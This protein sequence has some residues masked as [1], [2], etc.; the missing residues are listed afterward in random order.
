MFTKK[1]RVIS[2]IATVCMLISMLACVAIP[3]YAED[4]D[5][6]TYPSVQ[7]VTSVETRTATDYKVTNGADWKYLANN[8]KNF[9]STDV[10]IHLTDDIDLSGYTVTDFNSI[11]NPSFSLDGHGKTIKNLGTKE[12]LFKT[13]AIFRFQDNANTESGGG[14]KFIKNVTFS[15]CH[16]TGS[17]D[18][19]ALIMTNKGGNNGSIYLAPDFTMENVHIKESTLV[20]EA[21]LNAFFI[22]GYAT[23]KANYNVNMKNCSL[24]GS[25]MNAGASGHSG[26]LIG[27]LSDNNN[28][29]NGVVNLTNIYV[30]G[31]TFNA[32]RNAYDTMLIGNIEGGNVKVTLNNVYAGGNTVIYKAGAIGYIMNA[33]NGRDG[34]STNCQNTIVNGIVLQDNNMSTTATETARGFFTNM[35]GGTGTLNG[36]YTNDTKVT[37]NG[38]WAGGQ[39]GGNIA[40]TGKVG[41]SYM[42]SGEAAA[43]LNKNATADSAFWYT[44]TADG[45]ALGTAANAT[46]KVDLYVNGEVVKTYYANVDAGVTIAYEGATSYA[47]MEGSAGSVDAATGAVT[48]GG[49]NDVAVVVTLGDAAAKEVAKAA[50]EESIAYFTARNMDYYVAAAATELADAQAVYADDASEKEDYENAKAALDAFKTQ[51]VGKENAPSMTEIAQYPGAPV[52]V[53]RTA[54]DF[55]ALEDNKAKFGVNDTIYMVND[56]DMKGSTFNGMKDLKASFDGQGY[57]I[58]NWGIAA[59]GTT[60]AAITTPGLFGNSYGAAAAMKSIKNVT[61]VNCHTKSSDDCSAMLYG[62]GHANAG[63]AIDGANA[64]LTLENIHFDGCSITSVAKATK[65]EV[66]AFLLARYAINGADTYINVNNCSVVNSTL[67]ATAATADSGHFGLLIGKPR[68]DSVSHKGYY[69]LTDCYL[70]NNTLKYTRTDGGYIGV[71]FGTAEYQAGTKVTMKNVGVIGNNVTVGGTHVSLV[72]HVQTSAIDVDGLLVKGNTVT[73]GTAVLFRDGGNVTTKN[74]YCAD[75]A[76]VTTATSSATLAGTTID[77]AA[78]HAVNTASGGNLWWTTT[79]GAAVKGTAANAT[80]KVEL[81]LGTGEV[82][83]TY[84]A[85][86]GE[87]VTVAYAEEPMA[88]FSIEGESGTIADGNKVTVNKNADVVVAVSL[89]TAQELANAKAAL[90]AAINYYKVDRNINYFKA[91]VAT[92]VAEAEALLA[93]SNDTAA[94]L[95]EKDALDALQGEYVDAYPNIPAISELSLYN[96]GTFKNYKIMT[97]DDMVAAEGM[98]A[99]YA[100][101]IT[102]HLGANIDLT[103]KAFTDF[104]AASFDFDGHDFTISNWTNTNTTGMFQGYKGGT[105]KNIKIDNW[106]LDGGYGRALLAGN[107][108]SPTSNI[109]FENIHIKNSETDAK[110]GGNLGGYFI[111][112]VDKTVTITVK[113]CSVVDSK[114]ESSEDGDATNVGLIAGRV[115]RG[116]ETYVVE[117]FYVKGFANNASNLQASRGNGVLFGTLEHNDAT[118]NVTNAILVDCGGNGVISGIIGRAYNDGT[119]NVSNVI[120]AGGNLAAVNCM[121]DTFTKTTYTNVFTDKAAT[122]W[123]KAQDAAGIPTD[124]AVVEDRA[125]ITKLDAAAFKNGEAAWKLNNAA[126]KTLALVDDSF[127]AYPVMFATEG[128]AAPYQVN[129]VDVS[130]NNN[131]VATFYTNASGKLPAAAADVLAD[132]AYDW[133]L[134]GNDVT[135]DTVFTQSENVSSN[136]THNFN[137]TPEQID[138]TTTHKVPC[139]DDGCQAFKVVDCTA[140][141]Y[142]HKVVE[143]VHYHDAACVCQRVLSTDKCNITI[144]AAEGDTHNEDCDTCD[145][146]AN[147]DCVYTGWTHDETTFGAS[148]KHIGT[149]ACKDTKTADCTFGAWTPVSAPEM[150]KCGEEVQTCSACEYDNVRKIAML[151]DAAMIVGDTTAMV[152]DKIYVDIKVDAATGLSGV[153]ATITYNASELTYVNYVQAGGT[154]GFVEVSEVA[155]EGDVATLTIHAANGA[156][157]TGVQGIVT[158]EFAPVTSANDGDSYDITATVTEAAVISENVALPIVVA[159]DTGAVTMKTYDPGDVNNDGKVSIADAVMLLR[160]ISGQLDEDMINVHN[161]DLVEDGNATLT[162]AD[163]I[164]ILKLIL[165]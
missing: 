60:K 104:A 13:A 102:L 141:T 38:A 25:T 7:T 4:V 69:T 48:F 41:D 135:I 53:I 66:Y 101:G 35:Q 100:D 139:T 28:G 1:T 78:A 133:K 156:N 11:Y 51:Y 93:S 143:G 158:L 58:K 52:Y 15:N 49:N 12:T 119:V 161:A 44:T 145:Y 147:V 61:F 151:S 59:D 160:V 92:A 74:V 27:K 57:K 120:V 81:K 46:R 132:D 140:A 94:I 17:G 137:G 108:C 54:A 83:G 112:Q 154:F 20:G 45:V 29:K 55:Q 71:V 64:N 115:G 16:L 62:V 131:V 26:F 134:G 82:V 157:L 3:V 30:S 107:T 32:G 68:A 163:A 65:H 9:R 77:A 136:V 5:P 142:T 6:S 96:K 50:L 31:N 90:Q 118:I 19:S 129:F 36:A 121:L 34:V 42:T 162:T 63:M 87:T 126:G 89:G 80:R 22:G 105:I 146:N 113:N 124:T 10:T 67:D 165:A 95:A 110:T 106:T 155:I 159:D 128:Y 125:G 109:T 122:L 39:V 84:Y 75:E 8:Y 99:L 111:G 149:C 138:G 79:E 14:M 72:G 114:F 86:V 150:G 37:L 88:E 73:G 18:M 148:S 43:A 97:G 21:N 56:V 33:G 40:L 76:T 2:A 116:K 152:G 24:I 153:D 117:N 123:V 70:A 23:S 130:D 144:T 47:I 98:A 91:T 85:N 164:A 127:N 103:G